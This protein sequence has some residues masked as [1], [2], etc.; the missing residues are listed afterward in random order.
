MLI[1]TYRA[2]RS[3]ARAPGLVGFQLGYDIRRSALWTA[4]AWSTRTGLI[5]F[6]RSEIHR[7]AMA[8]LRPVL[9][10]STFVVW[11]TDAAG[12]PSGWDEIQRRIRAV[13][14]R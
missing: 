11:T 12:L 7:A 8:A 6:E 13:R 2:R 14:P 5:H 9:R 3:L 1:W 10:P 4:S